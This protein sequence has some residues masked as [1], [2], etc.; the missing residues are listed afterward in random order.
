MKPKVSV[1]IQARMGSTRLPGKVLK[2]LVGKSVIQHIVD[3]LRYSKYLNGFVI[4][5]SKES[6]DQVLIEKAKSLGVGGFA[7]SEQ[8]VLNRYYEASRVFPADHIVRVTAD[9]PLIDP[10]FVDAM[11]E[12]HLKNKNQY[13]S[14]IFKEYPN[15]IGAE[16]FR[17]EDLEAIEKAAR[18][19]HEREHV[20]PYFYL[21]P[22][23][24]KLEFIDPV[25]LIR[26]PD[27]RLTLDTAEDL[28]LVREIYG[29]LYEEG[30][31][32]TT[33]DIV[34]FLDERPELLKLNQHVKQK[35]LI[36]T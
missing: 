20:T 29:A 9:C 5:T 17:T 30:K 2:E 1:F 35:P 26:R 10:V 11:I 32:F 22:E 13:T 8:D 34:R 4:V 14:F 28:A 24:F 33:R 27:L 6:R 31:I 7:G 36:S 16:I 12:A 23:K 25:P 15:G 19:P 3:R 18:E 21:H